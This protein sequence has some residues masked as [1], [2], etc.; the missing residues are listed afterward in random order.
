M[1]TIEKMK[2]ALA[3]AAGMHDAWNKR[4]QETFDY[5]NGL[6]DLIGD[7]FRE[8]DFL[9]GLEFTGNIFHHNSITLKSKTVLES[10][11]PLFEHDGTKYTCGVLKT[12]IRKD[13]DGNEIK[14]PIR[15]H[16]AK[17]GTE[18]GLPWSITEEEIG[19]FLEQFGITLLGFKNELD[20]DKDYHSMDD[21][22]K[23]AKE[24]EEDLKP[25]KKYL[26]A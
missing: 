18:I 22:M 15:V 1:E 21:L 7:V 2:E 12:I 26:S 5:V 6:G 8:G 19:E 16:V 24:Y 20:Y 17:W 10:L 4:R 11:Y 3:V 9:R 23:M 25:F 14:V 13:E